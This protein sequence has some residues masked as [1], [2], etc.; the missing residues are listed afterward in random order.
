MDELTNREL[1]VLKLVARSPARVGPTSSATT[2]GHVV[3]TGNV[4]LP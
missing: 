3:F 4:S 1:D 2:I